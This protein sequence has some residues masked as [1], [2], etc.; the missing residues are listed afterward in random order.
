M[1]DSSGGAILIT[2]ASS[3]IGRAL[4]HK[5]AGAGYHLI[6]AGRDTDDLATAAADLRIRHNVEVFVEHFDALDPPSHMEFFS[7]CAILSSGLAGVILCHGYLA[8]QQHGQYNPQLVREIIDTNYT[9]AVSILELAANYFEPRRSGFICAIS[10]VAGDRGRQSNYLYG[11][12]KAALSTYLQGLR[13]RLYHAH[14][15]VLT[16]KPGFVD[17]PMTYGLPGLF[18]V[19]SPDKIVHDTWRAIQRKRNTIYTPFFWRFIMLIIRLIP[20]PIFKRLKL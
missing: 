19:A 20:E 16:V 15:P 6:L 18:L 17:T 4:A 1:T 12:A 13:N 7:R 8:P 11:S 5:A 10:S 14:I 9:S 3:G 2:G